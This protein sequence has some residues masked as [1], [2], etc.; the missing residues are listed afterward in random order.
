MP[1]LRTDLVSRKRRA[2]GDCVT[3]AASRVAA[4]RRTRATEPAGRPEFGDDKQLPAGIR[5]AMFRFHR[6]LSQVPRRRA[7][8]FPANITAAY[9]PQPQA[10][11]LSRANTHHAPVIQ[12]SNP[13]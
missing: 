13:R 1:C 4:E 11:C 5:P 2:G 7:V 10:G 6:R 12:A 3:A 9:R 8:P